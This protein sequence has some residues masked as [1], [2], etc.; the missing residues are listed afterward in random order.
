[1]PFVVRKPDGWKLMDVGFR[2]EVRSFS[3]KHVPL[4]ENFAAHAVIAM[5]NAPMPNEIRS[6]R[7]EAETALAD[8]HRTQDRL[9]QTERKASLGHLSVE[10]EPDVF[11]ELTITLPRRLASAE[12][13]KP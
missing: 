1:V 8:L 3:D 5:E 10:S 4:I 2:Q 12:E 7:D 11:A 13:R 9:V 6:A